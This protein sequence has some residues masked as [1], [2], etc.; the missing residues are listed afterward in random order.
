MTN[1]RLPPA[2]LYWSA[3]AP[4]QPASSGGV[5]LLTAGRQAAG[6]PGLPRRPPAA[7]GLPPRTGTDMDIPHHHIRSGNKAAHSAPR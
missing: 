1:R 6:V 4:G 5:R 2:G 7:F 3:L